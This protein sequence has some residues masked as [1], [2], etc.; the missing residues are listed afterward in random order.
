MIL[1]HPEMLLL[2]T[3]RGPVSRRQAAWQERR[4]LYPLATFP[5][6]AAQLLCLVAGE[7]PDQEDERPRLRGILHH[8][9][10]SNQTKIALARRMG[11]EI[12]WLGDMSL[13]LNCYE[14]AGHRPIQALEGWVEAVRLE[15][16]S[17]QLER[18]GFALLWRGSGGAFHECP[19][20]TVP[21]RLVTRLLPN[22]TDTGIPC[23]RLSEGLRLLAPERLLLRLCLARPHNAWG[24][25]DLLTLVPR[26]E[27]EAVRRVASDLRASLAVRQTI[28]RINRLGF[29]PLHCDLKGVP[30]YPGEWLE[31]LSGQRGLTAH[32]LAA[33]DHW[34]QLPAALWSYWK[35]RRA[36]PL[37]L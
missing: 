12:I 35:V 34:R 23:H 15:A 7:W 17:R 33:A 37:P 2:E 16:V 29:E 21:V 31:W 27:S 24:V 5:N 9:W 6:P 20:S 1:S 32:V 8:T 3:V 30:T 4:R 11:E 36:H 19:K 25:A 14:N 26:L 10:L 28:Q 18:E 22:R 13:L